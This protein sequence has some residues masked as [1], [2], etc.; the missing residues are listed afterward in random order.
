MIYSHFP[1]IAEIGIPLDIAFAQQDK[2]GITLYI[3][4]APP[5]SYLNP[6]TTSS[7]I[8][9]A[10]F[11]LQIFL[12]S[13]K[14]LIMPNQMGEIFKVLIAGKNIKNN[15]YKNFIRNDIMKL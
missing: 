15:S 14:K 7:K 12:T 10:P 5:I 9:K 4:W 2:S 6:V 13:I 3:F 8:N 1:V 11:F